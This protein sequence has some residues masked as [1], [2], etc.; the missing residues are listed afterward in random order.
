M[1][2]S[3]EGST[4]PARDASPTSSRSASTTSKA[5]T[6]HVAQFKGRRSVARSVSLATPPVSP[7]ICT[8]EKVPTLWVG[9]WKR[10]RQKSWR[11]DQWRPLLP[12]TRTSSLTNQV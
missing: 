5:P 11:M 1:A 10:F 12:C 6:H 9:V 2:L 3:L 8:T 4:T 7:T